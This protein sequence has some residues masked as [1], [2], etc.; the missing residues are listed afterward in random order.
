[1]FLDEILQTVFHAANVLRK[2]LTEFVIDA[3]ILLLHRTV[4]TR[5]F[6]LQK[7]NKRLKIISPFSIEFRVEFAYVV[8]GNI[9]DFEQFPGLCAQLLF[10]VRL[11]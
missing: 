10:S 2:A 5:E 8:G 11:V 1:M 3:L 7:R 4:K 6:H 9:S